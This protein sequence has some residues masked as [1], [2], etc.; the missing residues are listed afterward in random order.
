M[1]WEK[2]LK[3]PELQQPPMEEPPMEEPMVD[4]TTGLPIDPM[5]QQAGMAVPPQTPANPNPTGEEEFPVDPEIEDD[6]KLNKW[7]STLKQAGQAMTQAEYNAKYQTPNLAAVDPNKK[8]QEA[9]AAA[10]REKLAGEARAKQASQRIQADFQRRAKA[11]AKA[12]AK[13]NRKPLVTSVPQGTINPDAPLEAA[14]RA[15]LSGGK[16]ILGGGKQLASGAMAA[17]A[18]SATGREIVQGAKNIKQGL[19]EEKDT[20]MGAGKNVLDA[21]K[22]VFQTG[23]QA[24]ANPKGAVREAKKNLR[25]MGNETKESW[26]DAVKRRNERVYGG[27]ENPQQQ[28]EAEEKERIAERQKLLSERLKIRQEQQASGANKPRQ[29]TDPETGEVKDMERGYADTGIQEYDVSRQE[30]SL[31]QGMEIFD[32]ETPRQDDQERFMQ[33]KDASNQLGINWS[34]YKSQAGYRNKMQNDLK[35][36]YNITADEI[37]RFQDKVGQA[38]LSGEKVKP[39]LLTEE[40]RVEAFKRQNEGRSVTGAYLAGREDEVGDEEKKMDLQKQ[41]RRD[42]PALWESWDGGLVDY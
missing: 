16:R 36:K 25:A 24:I 10:L 11:G 23:Q 37:T 2:V 9:E 13:A 1:S 8:K 42:D 28:K 18:D 12:A 17:G 5:A 15:V 32:E 38:S 29:Y 6:A 30:R 4:P 14:G 39:R 33:F 27:Y 41:D 34:K 31:G 35:N 7:F 26:K 22:K 40:E 20:L 19:K 21:G 3:Q